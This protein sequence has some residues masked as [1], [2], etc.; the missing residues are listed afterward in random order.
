MSVLLVI[1][2]SK[3]GAQLWAMVWTAGDD[4]PRLLESRKFRG[5]GAFKVWLAGIVTRYGRSNIRV[6]CPESLEADDRLTVLLEESF[7]PI[8]PSARPSEV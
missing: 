4:D 3:A 5:E 7:G 2:R 8:P 1:E 6:T